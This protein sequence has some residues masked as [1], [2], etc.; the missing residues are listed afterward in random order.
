VLL[1]EVNI[2]TRK[3][4]KTKK[5]ATKRKKTNPTKKQREEQKNTNQNIV[6]VCLI[7]IGLYTCYA[8]LTAN[9]GILDKIIGKGIFSFTFGN[10]ST[11][12]SFY[13]III[14]LLLL[15]RKLKP[16]LK[17][18]IYIGFILISIMMVYSVNIPRLMEYSVV[19][20]FTLA[21]YGGYGGIIGITLCYFI[22]LLIAKPGLIAII[23]LSFVAEILLILRA[24][25]LEV[26][27]QLKKN[28]FG[29]APVAEKAGDVFEDSR[30]AIKQQIEKKKEKSNP[31]EDLTD[32]I[33]DASAGDEISIDTTMIDFV[34]KVRAVENGEMTLEEAVAKDQAEKNAQVDAIDLLQSKSNPIVDSETNVDKGEEMNLLSSVEASDYKLP[35]TSVLKKTVAKNDVK[36]EDVLKKAKVIEKTLLNFKIKAKI[37]GVD[38]GP[39]ITRFE[40]QPDAGVK[41]NKIVN[42]SDDL[43]LA[44]A[45]SDIRIEAPIP[46]KA[47]VGIEVPNEKSEIVG[48]R[49]IIESPAFQKSKNTLPFALGKTLSGQNIIGDISKMPHILIAGATGS[50]KSVCINAIIISLLYFCKPE[51]LKF[52]MIDPK[53]VELNQY[54][55]IPHMMIP[56][57]TDPKKAAH[58]LNWGIKEMTNRYQLFK[59]ASVRDIEGYNQVQATKGGQK[60][61]RIVIIVDELADLMM[62]SPKEV[63][64]AICR[65]AQLARACGI[66][67][68]IATQR[69][70]VDVITGL[71]KANIPSRIAFSVASNTD[72]RTILDMSGAEKL[73]GKGDMLYFPV[74]K[75]KPLRVQCAYVSDEEINRVIDSIKMTTGPTYDEKVEKEMQQVTPDE[76]HQPAKAQNEDSLIGEAIK[77]A[78]TYNQVSTSM[79]Q[80]KLRVGYARAG[81]LIDI[82]EERGIISGPN[83]SKP[84]KLL[85]SE[86]EYKDKI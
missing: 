78:F 48:I 74:G 35:S 14:G 53:M 6:G 40:L 1:S 37:I 63:E 19:K 17:T 3:Q 13:L 9:P 39:S 26:Y 71:I 38:I 42:L 36:R 69:P 41:V 21:K 27:K 77:I 70:S 54:N 44:L 45:T 49:E 24:N 68:V 15:L 85:L 61:P 23:I 8:F 76:G 7:I 5:T 2:V 59:D 82:L 33:F 16:N 20:L 52:I 65:I 22:Q 57:V 75:S 66:H 29:L 32:N 11:F 73:L 58:A 31:Q 80:R 67:L 25:F 84:R 10:G 43:S 51:D 72:S 81:R 60:L 55:A 34:D 46:G 86:T 64:N 62:T 28:Q 30:L 47:A 56:V 83:G 50:G 18:I 79:L 12:V 4:T